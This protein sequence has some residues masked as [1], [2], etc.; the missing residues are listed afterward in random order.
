M[1]FHNNFKQTQALPFAYFNIKFAHY[2][3]RWVLLLLFDLSSSLF[4]NSNLKYS[5]NL[6]SPFMAFYFLFYLADSF[7]NVCLSIELILSF[8]KLSFMFYLSSFFFRKLWI[9]L[10]LG[11]LS[12][13]S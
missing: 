1:Y 3:F 2:Q 12:A 6:Y 5:K 10:F 13:L 11:D 7:T 9:S 8:L 4:F